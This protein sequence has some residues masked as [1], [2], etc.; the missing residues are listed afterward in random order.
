M[1]VIPKTK[2]LI[3]AFLNHKEFP[4]HLVHK[5]KVKM[6]HMYQKLHLGVHPPDSNKT[7][8]SQRE[9]AGTKI[10]NEIN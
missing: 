8:T 5:E 2:Q 9:T 6:Y 3:K 7:A 1:Q 4:A 10:L